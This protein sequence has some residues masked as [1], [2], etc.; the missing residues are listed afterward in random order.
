MTRPHGK[1]S[2]GTNTSTI[3]YIPKWAQKIRDQKNRGPKWVREQ[4]AL[5]ALVTKRNAQ[6]VKHFKE[7]EE[8]KKQQQSDDEKKLD[9]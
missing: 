8:Q 2:T 1:G 3:I 9:K 6:I 7:Q 4:R 5:S